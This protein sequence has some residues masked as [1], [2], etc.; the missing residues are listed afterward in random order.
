[1]H[2]AVI[3][4]DRP[5]LATTRGPVAV[6]ERIQT[7]DV[8]R[9]FALLGI[10]LMNV[11]FFSR[12]LSDLGGGLPVGMTGLDH[13]AGWFVHTFVRGKFW[14]MF[15]MLFGMGFAVMLGRAR[16]TGRDFLWPYVRRTI[17]LA[18]FGL[19][20]GI[21]IWGGDILLA[22]A[23]AAMVLL[24]TLFG[25]FWHGLLIAAVLGAVGFAFKAEAVGGFV[26]LPVIAGLIAVY[27]R[28]E[29]S[30]Q[31]F[32]RPWPLLSIG[33]AIAALLMIVGGGI[34]IV[35]VGAA[36]AG[37]FVFGGTMIGVLAWLSRRYRN[38]PEKRTVRAGATLFLTLCLAMTIGSALSLM[39]PS[40]LKPK[41]TAEQT[42]KKEERREEHLKEVATETR[43]M[44]SGHYV[45]AVNLRTR[46]YLSEYASNSAF[47]AIVLFL[48][49]IGAWLVQSG[50]I[51]RPQ[52]HLGLFRKLAGIALPVGLV[53]SVAS[54]LIAT[55]Q[56]PGQNDAP[57]RLASSLQML[58][59]LPTSLGYIA[60]IVLLMQKAAWRQV[61]SWLAP[62]G[63]M[64][65]TNY[66]GASI[67]G[68]W[69]F[70]GYG[71]GQ[72]GMGRAGQFVFVLVVFALQVLLSHW[73]LSRFR[74][75]PLEWL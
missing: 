27:L 1:M 15:S 40:E 29:R 44:R 26:M 11:E 7:L 16:S 18:A 75:G 57:W 42:L 38:P 28:S 58:S 8:I 66:I 30:V 49:L 12:A 24:L 65:L 45:E 22:Y 60:V 33:L 32:G 35:M 43:V 13:A 14:T 63:R 31:I 67:I 61:L 47:S 50:A 53:L 70:Y 4:F 62:A 21:L 64:A 2:A 55:T 20:H 23:T 39:T 72:W 36:K 5:S 37:G 10:M 9:G 71:L 17:A 51:V 3:G 68:T 59:A 25:R 56:L 69:V 48:F 74:Y 52:E 73:W 34:G 54:S 46:T 41:P 19:L 6:H